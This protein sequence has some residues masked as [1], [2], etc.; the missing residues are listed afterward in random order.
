M[1]KD[2]QNPDWNINTVFNDFQNQFITELTHQL[3]EISLKE[4]VI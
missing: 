1:F 4:D 3:A 2:E